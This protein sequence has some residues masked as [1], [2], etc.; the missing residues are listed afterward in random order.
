VITVASVPARH[1]YVE[2]T[3][4]ANRVALL[5]DP[6]PAGATVPGQWW[7]PRWLDPDYLQSRLGEIDVLHVHFGFES[8]EPEQLEQVC[9]VTARHGVPLVVTVHDLHNPHVPDARSHQERLD[10]LV[11]AAAGVITLTEGA[12]RA[13]AHRWSREA[14]VLPH[15]ALLPPAAIGAPRPHRD[16]PVVALHA[17]YLRPNVDPWPVL[18]ALVT[19]QSTA[20]TLRLDLDD[21]AFRSP[22]AG[23]ALTERLQA[24]RD[25]GV[26]VRVHPPFSDDDL[27][28][29]LYDIDVLVLP[30]RFGSH[31]GWVEACWDAGVTAVVPDCGH[32]AEQQGSPS[33]GYGPDRFDPAGLLAA[34]ERAAATRTAGTDDMRRRVRAAQRQSIRDDM[35]AIYQ[36]L[37]RECRA[38]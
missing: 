23:A 17:K 21:N 31:S 25:R 19:A 24:Y 22:R 26:D 8:I 30:Y 9:T 28:D 37:I 12:S 3:I 10:I 34:V 38:A 11:P 36:R 5:A 35:V 6:V 29:Y 18:D 7:P 14:V 27:V 2:A 15:P 1:P 16:R 13:I 33:F 20:W 4:D 32:F